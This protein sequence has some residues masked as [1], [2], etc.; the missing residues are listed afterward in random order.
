MSDL[1]ERLK[2]ALADR[3]VVESEIGPTF[4]SQPRQGSADCVVVDDAGSRGTDGGDHPHIG[5]DLPA[6]GGCQHV[7]RH[8]VLL[9]SRVE[10]FERTSWGMP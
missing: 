3:Y 7:N 6:L 10:R 1:L 2:S 5:L 8:P 4:G 9:R